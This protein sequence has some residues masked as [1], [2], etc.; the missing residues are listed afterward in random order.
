M[1]LRGMHYVYPENLRVILSGED[2]PRIGQL[3]IYGCHGREPNSATSMLFP[4]P[5]EEP[6]DAPIPSRQLT[7]SPHLSHCWSCLP[8]LRRTRVGN[9][10][11]PAVQRPRTRF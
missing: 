8:R 1:S 2:S 10:R 3:I 5:P 4:V 11:H 7:V 9:S 6:L